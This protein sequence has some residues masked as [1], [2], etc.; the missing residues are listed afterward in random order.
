MPNAPAAPTEAKKNP[1][2][3]AAHHDA[4][5]KARE[6]EACDETVSG[7]V[8]AA[9]AA[10]KSLCNVPEARISLGCGLSEAQVEAFADALEVKV[11]RFVTMLTLFDDTTPRIIYSFHGEYEAALTGGKHSVAIDGQGSRAATVAEAR[12]HGVRKHED[13]TLLTG[14]D[15]AALVKAVQS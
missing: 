13:V 6:D 15:A 14:D 1:I 3:P 12:E 2:V 8:A 9:Y 11:S 7:M 4:L 5:M 10:A